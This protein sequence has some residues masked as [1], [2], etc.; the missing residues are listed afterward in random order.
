MKVEYIDKEYM[1]LGPEALVWLNRENLLKNIP[2]AVLVKQPGF[3]PLMKLDELIVFI[4]PHMMHTEHVVQVV[5]EYQR[6]CLFAYEKH[7]KE[8]FAEHSK[9]RKTELESMETKA[10][11]AE[12]ERFNRELTRRLG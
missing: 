7:M 4:T 10:I 12:V 1:I 3:K 8:L 11:L 6:R 9:I 2:Q 5:Y